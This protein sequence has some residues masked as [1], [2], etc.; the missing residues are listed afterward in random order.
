MNRLTSRLTKPLLLFFIAIQLFLISPPPSY[1]QN[2]NDNWVFNLQ[3]IGQSNDNAALGGSAF[4]PTMFRGLFSTMAGWACALSG[5]LFCTNNPAQVMNFQKNSAIGLSG[6][7]IASLYTPPASSIAWTMD[8]GRSLGLLPKPVYAQGIGFAGLNPVLGIW[9]A[10]R[11]IAY[12][13]MALIMFVIGFMIMFRKKIDPK[14]VVTVQNSLP[15]IVITLLL[16]TFSYAIAGLMIDLMYLVFYLMINVLVQNSNGI[17]SPGTLNNYVTGG[18]PTAATALFSAGWAS[19]NDII[20]FF[21]PGAATMEQ[22]LTSVVPDFGAQIGGAILYI[23][24]GSF[25]GGPVVGLL[26]LWLLVT[27]AIIFAMV[28]IF[29]ML[30]SAYINVII[31]II[32]APLQLLLEAFPGGDGFMSWIKNLLSNLAVFPITAVMLLIGTIL[33]NAGDKIAGG[34]GNLWLPPLLGIGT[35]IPTIDQTYMPLFGLT[36]A[37]GTNAAHGAAGLIGLGIL[38]TIPSVV[39]GLKE[40]LK[41]KPPVNAGIGAVIGPMGGGLSQLMQFAYQYR[42]I[43]GSHGGEKPKPGTGDLPAAVDTAKRASR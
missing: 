28:R 42:I 12:V 1:A 43:F 5:L 41:A 3:T 39:N 34:A 23:F 17:L 19:I 10:F 6:N 30:L 26:V 11:N 21:N 24:G 40:A 16:I 18:F 29:F 31:S 20:R 37:P 8:T 15:R 9:K 36:P 7:M 13:I 25:A 35:L 2:I 14:T 22:W 27:I 4:E 32:F 38:S 33:T